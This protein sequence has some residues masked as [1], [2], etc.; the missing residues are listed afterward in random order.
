MVNFKEGKLIVDIEKSRKS[1]SVTRKAAILSRLYLIAVLGIILTAAVGCAGVTKGPVLLRVSEDRAALMWETEVEGPGN[2]LYGKGNV[3]DREVTTEPIQVEYGSNKKAAFIHKTWLENLQPGQAYSYRVAS[4]KIPVLQRIATLGRSRV[5]SKVYEFRTVPDDTNEVTFLVYGDTRTKPKVHRRVVEQMLD[6]KADFV[7]H[8]GDL[9]SS[10]DNYEQFGPQFFEPVKGLAETVPFYIAK[11]NHEG[12]K[13]NYEKLL[14]PDGRTNTFGVDYGPVHVFCVDNYSSGLTDRE[15]LKQ[16]ADDARKSNARWKF[17]S[18]H[19][20]SLNL[21]GHWSDWG[22]P[23]ALRLLSEAGVDFV[24]TGHSHQYER[25]WP[26]APPAGADGA[27]VTHI[28]CGGG[29]APL[30]GV[31]TSL[32]HAKA[33]AENH[34][35]FF[36]IND[37]KLTMDTFDIDGKVIDHLE[38]IKTDGRLN[39]QYLWTAIPMA[40]VRLHQDLYR[41]KPKQLSKKPKKDRPFNVTYKLSVPALG[42]PAKMTFKLHCNKGTYRLQGPKTLTIPKEGGTF[43]VELT[44]TPLVDVK[45][46]KNKKPIV[47]ELR[48]EC[49]YEIGRVKE[50][51]SHSIIAKL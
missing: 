40:A 50:H 44:A 31:K 51:I 25:F 38:I 30:Y 6:K 7:V 35:C 20:P 15:L 47:P 8:S 23:D 2:V 43:N 36:N 49:H 5:Q 33:T 1:L 14:V 41:A 10:G 18:Y 48:L 29:G 28:T 16:I 46:P 17:V 9:V 21:G 19:K 26:I 22:Y 39:K 34:F 32:Y 12:K 24:L 45:V 13:G 11:G 3:L 4:E 42:E 27:Y 37:N